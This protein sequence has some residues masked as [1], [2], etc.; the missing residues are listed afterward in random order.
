MYATG[1][2]VIYSIPEHSLIAS[3][4]NN[5]WTEGLAEVTQAKLSK[6][7]TYGKSSTLL[8]EIQWSYVCVRFGIL[9]FS[10]SV[11]FTGFSGPRS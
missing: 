10:K 9:N 7:L 6:S 3:P 4:S 2:P 8:W 1:A 5:L 11:H